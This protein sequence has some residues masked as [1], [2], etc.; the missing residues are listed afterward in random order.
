MKSWTGIFEKN[1]RTPG[2]G[3]QLP[4]RL[5]TPPKSSV[6]TSYWRWLDSISW[7]KKSTELLILKKGGVWPMSL[8]K[9]DQRWKSVSINSKE[10]RQR[11]PV[12]KEERFETACPDCGERIYVSGGCPVCIFC[13]WSKC[14]WTENV[15]NQFGASFFRKEKSIT[16]KR[17]CLLPV[18]RAANQTWLQEVKYHVERTNKRKT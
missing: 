17:V 7:L 10:T 6:P 15:N 14:L 18:L 13:G 3:F 5:P 9:E 1:W 16:M 2:T 8:I 12:K 11:N 4:C